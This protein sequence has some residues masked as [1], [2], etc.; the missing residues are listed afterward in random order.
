MKNKVKNKMKIFTFLQF[1]CHKDVYG[2]GSPPSGI[3]KV[4]T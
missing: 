2:S 4:I 1:F 3:F